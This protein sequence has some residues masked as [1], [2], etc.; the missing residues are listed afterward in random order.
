MIN[1]KKKILGIT[2]TSLLSTS[3]FAV[4]ISNSNSTGNNNE[5]ITS[6]TGVD[7]TST[8]IQTGDRNKAET[9]QSI[10]GN[11]AQVKQGGFDNFSKVGQTGI[12]NIATVDQIGSFES[13]NDNLSEIL[14]IGDENVTTLIQDYWDLSYIS[15]SGSKN[16]IW[17]DQADS[18]GKGH[19]KSTIFQEGDGNR[20]RVTQSSTQNTVTVHQIGDDNQ[21]KI[22]QGGQRNHI[23]TVN[24]KGSNNNT[25]MAQSGLRNTATINQEEGNFATVVQDGMGAFLSENTVLINQQGQADRA[26]AEQHGDKANSIII[27]Q[28]GSGVVNSNRATAIQTGAANRA[29]IFQLP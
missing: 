27:N 13:G 21:A 1:S 7:L 14:Q 2:I 26:V 25:D 28:G 8:I 22:E 16:D 3:V 11:Q 9:I 12:A 5:V 17:V 15:Q 24:Q 29:T 6:Q 23:A 10:G 19:N 18:L 20:A 4:N